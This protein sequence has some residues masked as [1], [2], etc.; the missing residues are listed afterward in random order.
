MKNKI[1]TFLYLINLS[2][3]CSF[4]QSQIDAYSTVTKFIL[5]TEIT[6]N[7][8]NASSQMLND[9]KTTYTYDDYGKMTNYIVNNWNDSQWKNEAKTE[10]NYDSDRHLIQTKDYYWSDTQ[11]WIANQKIEYTYD[12]NGNLSQEIHYNWNLHNW[13]QYNKGEYIYDTDERR[14]KDI[15]YSWDSGHWIISMEIEYNYNNDKLIQKVLLINFWDNYKMDYSYDTIGNLTQTI[16]YVSSNPWAIMGK[17]EYTYDEYGNPSQSIYYG[18]NE[19]LSQ[20]YNSEKVEYSYNNSCSSSDLVLPYFYDN[21]EY[22]IVYLHQMLP[23]NMFYIGL[24]VKIRDMFFRHMMTN[25]L[26][27]DWNSDLSTWELTQTYDYSYSESEILS[28]SNVTPEQIKIYPNPVT[29]YLNIQLTNEL[30][31]E[32]IK[33]FNALGQLIKDSSKSS[34]DVS[35]LNKGLYYARIETNKGKATKKVIIK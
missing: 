10:F 3:L 16:S 33:L 9:W 28:I 17:T 13:E 2:S 12:S 24:D 5:E 34:I 18:W 14:I 20:W 7:W 4:S 26:E 32:S 35:N 23:Q 19:T 22:S 15:Y 27:Y 8:D 1:I 6:Q 29:E 30:R 21:E 25:S 31:L 11:Q